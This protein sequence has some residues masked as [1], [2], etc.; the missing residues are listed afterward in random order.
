MRLRP[1]IISEPVVICICGGDLLTICLK[2]EIGIV[3]PFSCNISLSI[4]DI[5]KYF[6]L[7]T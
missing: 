7:S 1:G 3:M 4:D 5:L 2:S 6:L